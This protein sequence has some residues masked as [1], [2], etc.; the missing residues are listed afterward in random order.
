MRL[1]AI[2]ADL[3]TARTAVSAGATVVQL[4][5]K[6]AATEAVVDV[7]G[8]AVDRL[9]VWEEVRSPGLDLGGAHRPQ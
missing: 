1:H 2:V 7:A 6:G 5:V 9:H 3:D 4:R 8:G